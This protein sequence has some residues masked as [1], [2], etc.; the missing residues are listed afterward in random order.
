MERF[1]ALRLSAV[2]LALALLLLT[3]IAYAEEGTVKSGEYSR[4]W[5]PSWSAVNERTIILNPSLVLAAL[6]AVF[7]VLGLYAVIRSL[8]ILVVPT[9]RVKNTDAATSKVQRI[10]VP[11]MRGLRFDLWLGRKKRWKRGPGLRLKLFIFAIILVL[12][13]IIMVLAP[14]YYMMVISPQEIPLETIV[15][16]A[17]AAL[18]V[19]IIG[20]VI[21]SLLLLLPIRKLVRHVELI[22]DTENKESLA[23]LEFRINSRDEA[24]ILGDTINDMARGLAK[25]DATA[26]ELSRGREIQKKFLPL[27]IDDDGTVLNISHKETPNAIF[28]GY[29]EGAGDISGDYFDYRDL[30]GRY[31]AIIK[32]D[33]AGKGI[34]A[35]LIM[36]Q[37]ATMFLNFFK[38][39]KPSADNIPINELVYQ[40]NGFIETLGFK[41]RF[42]AFT[43]CVFDSETGV[44]QL[45]NAGDNII[46]IFDS[47]ENRLKS[48]KL[49]QTPAAGALPNRIIE[50]D[51]GYPVQNLKLDHDDIL[52]LY[53]DGIVESKR[54]FRDA[55]FNE[56]TCTGGHEGILHGSHKTGEAGEEMGPRRVQGIVNA[57]MSRGTYNLYKWHNPKGEE[58]LCFDFSACQGG[59]DDIIMALIAVEKIFRCYRDGSADENDW[60]FVDRKVD[61]FLKAHFLQYPVY[62]AN[63][64]ECTGN[65]SYMYYTHLK[66][67]EQYDDLTIL[68]I[69]RK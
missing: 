23:N 6:L 57:V 17:L 13:V 32:C 64:C 42:A 10:K 52:L 14:L 28:S 48:I 19:G 37:V 18:A 29:Y 58:D 7:S 38:Q 24:A 68:G 62:C 36:V 49:P 15:I 54:K 61:A 43:L 2:V 25:A 41:N 5:Q 12:V 59:L 39:W 22:R 60:V 67:D 50:I 26:S 47:S 27:D 63:T 34:P 30:D 45:C 1:F 21:L 31:Y 20:A 35:A 46:H 4:V 55:L 65:S 66:E 51:C 9:S 44:I 40:I 53:T 11:I 33:V 16:I 56:I 69:K 8:H 3:P